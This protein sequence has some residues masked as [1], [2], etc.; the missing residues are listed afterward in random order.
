MGTELP[1]GASLCEDSG[2]AV[3]GPPEASSAFHNFAPAKIQ[4]LWRPG[5]Q[6][7]NVGGLSFRP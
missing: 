4:P 5:L 7:M 1:L 6:R 2:A 3:P